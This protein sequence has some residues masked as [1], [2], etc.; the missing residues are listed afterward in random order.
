MKPAIWSSYLMDL[1]PEEMVREFAALGWMELELGDEHGAMLLARREPVKVG[2]TFQAFAAGQGVSFPQGHLW[3]MCDIA[4][5]DQTATLDRLRV[6]LDLFVAV[7]VKAGVLHPGG[8]ELASKGASPARILDAQVKA[9]RVIAAHL[10]GAGMTI[11][12]ENVDKQQAGEL[13]TII[14]AAGGEGLAICL[15]TG[16]LNVIKG[17]QGKFIRESGR[18]LQALHLHDND[19]S[20]DQHLLPYGV[21]NIDW[22]DVFAAL[23]EIRYQGLMNFEIPGERRGPLSVRLAKLDYLRAIWPALWAGQMLDYEDLRTAALAASA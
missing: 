13:R 22:A 5:V 4:A 21:G 19:G 10:R 3:L 14:D 20:G 1:A 9:L 15:D 18:L 16:H 7:G 12:L 2:R 23:K 8:D 6:W 11:C 17:N